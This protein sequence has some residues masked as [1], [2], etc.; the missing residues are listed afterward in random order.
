[1]E[2]FTSLYRDV[3]YGGRKDEDAERTTAKSLLK[4]IKASSDKKEA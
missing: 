2:A 4:K 3:R 1:M